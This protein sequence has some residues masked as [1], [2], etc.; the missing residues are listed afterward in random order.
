ML[1]PVVQK[2]DVYPDIDMELLVCASEPIAPESLRAAGAQDRDAVA[3]EA[4]SRLA[5]A[6]CRGKLM[7][8]REL[9]ATWPKD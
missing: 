4:A 7:K 6:D 1:P 2:V 5:G 8:L 3:Y 9:V